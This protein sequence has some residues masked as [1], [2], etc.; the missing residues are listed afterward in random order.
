MPE[1]GTAYTAGDELTGGGT[2]IYVGPLSGFSHTGLEPNIVAYYYKAWSGDPDN[3]DV[4]SPT[5]VTANAATLCS[6]ASIPYFESFEYGGTTV[7]CGSVLDANDNFDTWFA[8][9]GFARTGAISLRINGGFSSSP[10]NDWYFTNALELTA[11]HLYQVKFWYRTQNVNGAA[12]QIEVKWGNGNSVAGMTSSPIYYNNNLTP[13]SS[14]TQITCTLFSPDASGVYYIGWHNFTPVSPGSALFMEDITVT[15][16]PLPAP[17][18]MLTATA[19][20]ST[21]SLAYNLNEAGDQVIIATNTTDV[22]DNPGQGT[23]YNVGA[24]IG[25]NGTIIYKGTL[26]AFDHTGLDANTTFYYKAWSVDASNYYSA[27]ITA[28]ATTGDYQLICVPAGWGGISAYKVPEVPALETVLSEINDEM[29]IMVGRTGFYWPGQNINTLGNWDSNQGYKL[30][31]NEPGCFTIT[32]VMSE[33]K[34]INVPQGA[35]YIPVLCDHPVTASGIFSQFGNKLLFAFDL[36][37]ELIYWPDGGLYSLSVLEPGVGYLVNLNQQA[38]ATYTCDGDN[39]I[40]LAKVQATAYENAPWT[41]SK[42]DVQHFISIHHTAVADLVK[43]DF[44]GVFNAQG[45]CVGF[46]QYNGQQGN[47]LLVAYGD[48]LTTDDTDGLMA[49]EMMTFR[50]YNPAQMI[51]NAVDVNFSSSMPNAGSFVEMGLSMILKMGAGA[52]A[53]HENV[54]SEITLHPN[55]SNGIFN[56]EL[57]SIGQLISITVENS[58][59]KLIYSEQL[60]YSATTSTHQLDLTKSRPGVYFVRISSNNQTV[61]KK[62]V[63]L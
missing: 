2:V 11:G 51:E 16:I 46:T 37:S 47:L 25:G 10:K 40:N 14:Y 24:V 57:P 59:G 45:N 17:P 21:I 32:G 5:G 56:M 8:N 1:N 63:V 28:D 52:A 38:S 48:D 26:E 39:K 34:T 50:V 35:S 55:P 31:M 18:T 60:D 58:D 53:I 23:A 3:G 20:L 7:G 6:T 19:N 36:G 9:F 43:G 33:N 12:H 13:I 15:E 49:G 4:Y 41:Y 27:G 61:V 42:S 62:V 22:F 44:I 30:K 54:L 29:Q